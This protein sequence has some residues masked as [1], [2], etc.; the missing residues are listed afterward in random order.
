MNLKL[1]VTSEFSRIRY[2]Q[3]NSLSHYTMLTITIKCQKA[4]KSVANYF[5]RDYLNPRVE[6]DTD[7]Q[8]VDVILPVTFSQLTTDTELSSGVHLYTALYTLYRDWEKEEGEVRRVTIEGG[9]RGR[10]RE[11]VIIFFKYV[12]SHVQREHIF[13]N[14]RY[15]D[16]S[17]NHNGI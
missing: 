7:W 9:E 3:I 12:N 10:S 16:N 15:S 8:Y 14:Y 6:H 1:C 13:L 5:L 11:W 17:P 2:Y 4:K